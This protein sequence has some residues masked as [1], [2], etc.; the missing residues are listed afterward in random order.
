MTRTKTEALYADPG[1]AQFYDFGLRP[2]IEFSFCMELAPAGCTVLDLGCGTGELAA[3]LATE[4]KRSR[5]VVGVD[6]AESMLDIARRRP[7]GD[8]VEWI[9]A[10]ARTV[11][12]PDRFDLILLTGHTFQVFLND[13]DQVA[14]LRTIA[15]H[16]KP[17]GRFVLDSR[18]PDFPEPKERT[19]DANRRQFDHPGLGRIEAWNSSR[20]REEA[21]ILSYRNGYRVLSTGETFSADA[22]IRYTP[23][24]TLETL[25]S[26]SGLAADRWLGDWTGRPFHPTA[27]EIIPLG[28]LA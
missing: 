6:P 25:L 18:N 9:C 21:G 7:G 23:R 15:A 10:D 3:K 5:R 2:R 14:V 1:L 27:R 17:D 13:N 22:R 20:Y 26:K 16:L 19:A 24:D 12:L 4:P 8:R 11:R 28:R